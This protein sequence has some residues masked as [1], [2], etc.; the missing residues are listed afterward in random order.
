MSLAGAKKAILEGFKVEVITQQ[1]HTGH[2]IQ[3]SWSKTHQF[4]LIACNSFSVIASS[5][6]D[7]DYYSDEE[8]QI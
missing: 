2:S 7:L 3:I 8:S 6:D 5:A 1:C 4:W